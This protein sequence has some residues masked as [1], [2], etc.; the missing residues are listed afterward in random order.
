[1]ACLAPFK[2]VLDHS[3]DPYGTSVVATAYYTPTGTL[4]SLVRSNG[5]TDY[6]I[7]DVNMMSRPKRLAT[8]G[9]V[10]AGGGDGDWNSGLISYDGAGRIHQ[11]GLDTYRY[12]DVGRLTLANVTM[13]GDEAWSYGTSYDAF[14]SVTTLSAVGPG[15]NTT[16]TIPIDSAS[17]RVS[18][19]VYDWSGN[20]IRPAPTLMQANSWDPLGRLAGYSPV[21][22]QDRSYGYDLDG[23]R[24]VTYG[25]GQP[26]APF[27]LV[28]YELRDLFGRPI[29]EYQHTSDGELEWSRDRIFLGR[30]AIASQASTA[31][32]T[33]G[34]LLHEHRDHLGSLRLITDPGGVAVAE[35]A[36]SP[37]GEAW[38]ASVDETLQFTGHEREPGFGWDYMHARYYTPEWGR[39]WSVDPIGGTPGRP[40]SWN[41]Y[42]YV[43]G[44]PVNLID[45]YGLEIGD[46]TLDYIA[47][48]HHGGSLVTATFYS[49]DLWGALHFLNPDRDRGGAFGGGGAS[50]Y[51]P[52][53]WSGRTG[54]D[55]SR[56][57]LDFQFTAFDNW[58]AGLDPSID[59]WLNPLG[60]LS[61]GFADTITFGVTKFLRPADSVDTSSG[62]YT[63]GEVG[64]VAWG[65]AAGGGAAARAVGRSPLGRSLL[66]NALLGKGG[67][68]FGRGGAHGAKGIMNRGFMRLGWGWHGARDSHVFR[69]S[70]GNRGGG[71]IYNYLRHMDIMFVSDM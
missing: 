71:R 5:V 40:Q 60:S 34:Q 14:G 46:F 21:S 8:V 31:W 24:V 6:T 48:D 47:P 11:M 45:P 65:V 59:R 29:R 22:A 44:D 56:L 38:S 49:L 2:R 57:G 52:V 3:I 51:D 58:V 26:G 41:R 27:A 50:S 19:A 62:W 7:Q 12:D 54:S 39:F 67:T 28:T 15:T 69:L 4:G 35:Q 63:A 18:G 70:V 43:M 23:D 64:G 68:L 17:N 13:P 32:P 37:F 25:I 36:F 1:M 66:D 20:M 16:T 61:T 42:A 55:P 53:P 33:G 10:T 9:A 30:N